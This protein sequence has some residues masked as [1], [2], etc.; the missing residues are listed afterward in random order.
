[1]DETRTNTLPTMKTEE[2]VNLNKMNDSFEQID[3]KIEKEGI[4]RKSDFYSTPNSSK[5]STPIREI[6]ITYKYKKLGNTYSFWYNKRGEPLFVI[7]PHCKY[8]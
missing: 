2:M 1:M 7:G 4:M 3:L 6:S 5:I 8:Y